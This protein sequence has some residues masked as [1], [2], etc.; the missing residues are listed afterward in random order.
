MTGVASARIKAEAYALGFDLVGVTTLGPMETA[1]AFREWLAK[2]HA[3]TMGYLERG[4]DKRDD[5]RRVFDGA[6]SAV[7]VAMN[8]GGTQPSG[9]I[10]RYARGRDYHDVIVDRLNELLSRIRDVIAPGVNGKP[11]VDTGPILERDLARRAGLGWFGKNTNLI[12]PDLGSFFFIGSLLLD[13]DLA[14]DE[15]FATDHCGTCTR[16]LQAC[17]TQAFDGPG[18]LDATKCISYLTIELRDAIPLALRERIGG[19]VFGCDICQEVCPWNVKFSRDVTDAELQPTPAVA[20]STPVELLGLSEEGFRA[21]FRH[22]P[23]TRAKRKGLA[24]N[25]A[26]ALGNTG[27]ADTMSDLQRALQDAEPLV[28]EHAL[29]ALERI[30]VRHA[31][32]DR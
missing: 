27:S 24:R 16:C 30:A 11:Y 31:P 28:R 29:W 2:G 15:P 23:V 32:E 12:N 13:V 7:V 14:P 19:L 10:A 22:S 9:P 18:V 20:S 26:V 4:A 1:P 25:A 6:V 5:S 21:R 17:P 3:G 8:Y